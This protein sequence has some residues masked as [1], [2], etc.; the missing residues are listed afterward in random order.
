MFLI[1]EPSPLLILTPLGSKYLPQD[2]IFKY[3]TL[4][5]HSSLNVRDHVSQSYNTTGNII[6]LYILIFK[7]LGGSREDQSVWT[8]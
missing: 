6:V 2:L 8:E 3:G 4:S 7:F 5:L 1:V